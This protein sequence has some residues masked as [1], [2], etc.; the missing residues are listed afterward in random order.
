MLKK[1]QDGEVN[2]EDLFKVFK[3]C[4]KEEQDKQGDTPTQ[5]EEELTRRRRSPNWGGGK[6][7]KKWEKKMVNYITCYI[8]NLEISEWKYLTCFFYS[9]QV[10]VL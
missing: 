6:G 2:M 5:D 8:I 1:C 7:G 10:S 3:E 9:A 4:K